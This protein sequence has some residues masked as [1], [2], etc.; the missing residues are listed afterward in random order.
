MI[1]FVL[2]ELKLRV[3]VFIFVKYS[4]DTNVETRVL[5]DFI[6]QIEHGVVLEVCWQMSFSRLI[7]TRELGHV[8]N[9][10]G[11]FWTHDEV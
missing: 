7:R 3:D 2:S 11:N 1:V 4:I 6:G 10:S 8:S 9:S 5:N